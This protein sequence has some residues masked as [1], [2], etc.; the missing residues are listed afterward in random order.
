MNGIFALFLLVA[1]RPVIGGLDRPVQVVSSHDGSGRL[2]IAE[3]PGRIVLFDGS[4]TL[5][6]AFLDISA[7]VSCCDNGGLL[8][9]AFHPNYAKNGLLYVLYVDTGGDTVVAE[10]RRVPSD[11]THADP[12]SARTLILVDQPASEVPNHHG[13]T[14]QFG[15][16][17]YLYISIGDGGTTRGVTD[18]AQDLRTLFGKLLRIDVNHGTPYAIPDDNPY[19]MGGAAPEIWALG[20][21]NP[22]RFSFDRATGQLILG[23]VGEDAWEELDVI[24]LLQSRGANFGWPITEGKHCFPAGTSCSTAGITLPAVEYGHDSIC[25]SITAGYR[26]RGALVPEL[27]GSVIYGDWCSGK[28]WSATSEGAG[29]WHTTLLEQTPHAIVSFGED[30]GGE[31]YVV[32]YLGSVLRME[33]APPRRHAA[34]H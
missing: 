31:L 22:W 1:L 16:D 15:P 5:S 10:Y 7:L 20:L 3:Q 13:G 23:D 33:T 26:Y 24:G 2:F 32:D 25:T 4:E 34:R 19:R 27:Q 11:A 8:S 6:P 14:L 29:E 18:R 28:L 12:E 30:D 17:G 21:R 9:V